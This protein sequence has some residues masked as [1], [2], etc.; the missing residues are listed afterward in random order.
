M[1]HREKVL[2]KW[3]GAAYNANGVGEWCGEAVLLNCSDTPTAFAH[4]LAS[5]FL[6]YATYSENHQELILISF[7]HIY[8]ASLLA[9]QVSPGLA[10]AMPLNWQPPH[11][12]TNAY[13][14]LIDLANR[15]SWLHSPGHGCFPPQH[16]ATPRSQRMEWRAV[17]P[18]RP[19]VKSPKRVRP[20]TFWGDFRSRA[21]LINSQNSRRYS[22]PAV[23]ARACG[24]SH[25]G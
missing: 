20:E 12:I 9:S 7:L 15:S 16:P 2:E 18:V 10:K 1:A 6:N 4:S 3:A 5:R 11:G 14:S 22:H 8:V 21:K 13:V 19:F 23:F 17:E 25:S 24:S